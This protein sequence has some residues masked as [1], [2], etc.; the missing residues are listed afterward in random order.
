MFC[1]LNMIGQADVGIFGYVWMLSQ[2]DVT[3]LC[4]ASIG[5]KNTC[6]IFFHE[7]RAVTFAVSQKDSIIDSVIEDWQKKYI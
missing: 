2:A 5:R 1:E 7:R 4:T 6:A 3:F